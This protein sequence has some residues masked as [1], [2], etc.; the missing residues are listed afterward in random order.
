MGNVQLIENVFQR[1]SLAKAE[2]RVDLPA[3]KVGHAIDLLIQQRVVGFCNHNQLVVNAF[4][5]NVIVFRFVL[6]RPIKVVDDVI[7]TGNEELAECFGRGV[8]VAI[9]EHPCLDCGEL[10]AHLDFVE[11]RLFGSD[12]RNPVHDRSQYESVLDTSRTDN[13]FDEHRFLGNEWWCE[14]EIVVGSIVKC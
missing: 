11:S 12:G 5:D 14:L 4:I 6:A 13:R 3:N 7:H 8:P 2:S 1:R 10:T 9:H